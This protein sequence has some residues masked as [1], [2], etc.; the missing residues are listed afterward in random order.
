MKKNLSKIGRYSNY[1]VAMLLLLSYLVPYLPPKHFGYLSVLGLLTPILLLINCLFAIYWL[2]RRRQLV[3]ISG[4]ALCLG[5]GLVGLWVQPFG[6]NEE[7]KAN[8]LKLLSF[9]V[10]LF[11]HYH[12]H[13]DEDLYKRITSFIANESADII[14]LQEFYN[15]PLYYP[16]GY[17]YKAIVVKQQRHKIGLAIF[18]KKKIVNWGSL[19]FPK[20]A[21]NAMYADILTDNDT[22][23]V[24]NMHLESLHVSAKEEDLWEEDKEELVENISRRFAKQQEQVSLF[25][26]HQAQCK[27]KV[28]VTGDFN[29]TAY[30]YIYRQVRGNKLNDAFQEAG[31]GFGRTFNFA[32]FP[33][34][35][36]FI[37][38]DKKF[39]I[40]SFKTHYLPLSDHFPLTTTISKITD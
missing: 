23:R 35:I 7:A 9:N 14:L 26:A 34:R 39:R 21:N 12:W 4:V 20:T 40:H 1:V 10:R 2:I 37:L 15:S 25:L 13:P 33:F 32:Y 11:N 16:K 6:R 5:L 18:S 28:I 38:V 3:L 22:V 8:S 36:D 17:P 29:N 24:Y 27:H 30:S 31:R 19:Q